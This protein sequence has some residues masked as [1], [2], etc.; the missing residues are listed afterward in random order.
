MTEDDGR[1]PEG[2]AKRKATKLKRRDWDVAVCMDA[3]DPDRRWRY[4]YPVTGSGEALLGM[5]ER[6]TCGTC[7]ESWLA[8]P[9][10]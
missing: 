10:R 3:A 6:Q 2:D 7:G 1:T 8:H 5:A 4:H 9:R